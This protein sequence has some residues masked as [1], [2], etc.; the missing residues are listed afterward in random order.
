MS[1]YETFITVTVCAGAIGYGLK[2]LYQWAYDKGY[3]ASQTDENM[4]HKYQLDGLRDEVK[5]LKSK[6]R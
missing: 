6:S 1:L 2:S 3:N 4:I 5:A